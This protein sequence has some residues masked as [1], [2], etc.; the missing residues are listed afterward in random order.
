MKISFLGA[1][2][3]GSMLGALL[4]QCAPELDVQL[5]VRGAHGEAI[6][7]CG[8]VEIRGPWETKQ[9]Q[10]AWSFDPTDIA[11]SDIVF[12]TV[13]SQDTEQALHQAKDAIGDAIVVSVQN[14]INDSRY[15][16]YVTDDRLVMGMTTTN[17]AVVE[18]GVV[19]MQLDGPT[20]FGTPHGT[21]VP[22]GTVPPGVQ[23]V[24]DLLSRITKPGLS[25]AAHPNILG[26]RYNKLTLNA[27]GY[28]SCLSNS[29]FMTEA[30]FHTQWR[31]TVARPIVE[32]CRGIF[33]ACGIE[34]AKIPGR[35]DLSRVESLMRVLKLPIVGKIV[36][37]ALRRR[38]THSPIVFS[39]LQDLSR[40]KPTEVEYINGQI[41]QLALEGA[42]LA[43]VNAELVRLTH[44]L[45][46]RPAGSFFTRQ[47]V[48][49]RVG[50][51]TRA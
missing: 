10:L 28:A 5:I 1:G 25:F 39:L 38:F 19:A 22:A 36:Q 8:K 20:L 48:I 41:V 30:L 12:V 47:E 4:R 9:V 17:M 40:G 46:A 37:L 26:I 15:T 6:A 2:A 43:P 14:G 29:N 45:E 11:G 21:E 49:D 44:E 42:C 23:Q 13:K 35:S 51:A 50:Q 32:E 27:L 33:N 16:D 34:L 31:E 24:V 18:P 3:I 7:E